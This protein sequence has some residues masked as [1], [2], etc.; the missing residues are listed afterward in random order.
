MRFLKRIRFTQISFIL[1]MVCVFAPCLMG[2][3]ITTALEGYWTFDD[4]DGI[5]TSDLSGNSRDA[6][7]HDGQPIPAAGKLGNAVYFDGTSDFTVPYKGVMGNTSR[8]ISVW[9][10]TG[11][12]DGG[13]ITS[14]GPNNTGEKWHFRP[15]HSSGN[16]VIGAI[17]T[18][19][20]GSQTVATT[21]IDDNQWHHVV[22]VFEGDFP[23]NVVHYVD[24][25]L[26]PQSWVGATDVQI[27]TTE[28]EDVTIG[29]R[30]QGT[31]YNH[32]TGT[33]DEMRI[34]SR[35]LSAE[36]V[37]ALYDEANVSQKVAIRSIGGS[38][39]APGIPIDVTLDIQIP[40]EG[41]LTEIIPIGW[42]ASSVSDGGTVSGMTITWNLTTAIS[43]VSYTAE[44][45]GDTPGNVFQGRLDNLYTGGDM[46][47]TT[48]ADGVGDF[49]FHSDIGGVQAKG[50]AEY[51]GTE[52]VIRGSGVD[53]WGTAD[54]F[55]YAFSEIEGPFIIRG[56]AFIDPGESS[57]AWVKGGLMI[58][59]N[60]S[61]ASSYGYLLVRTDYQMA[62]QS[63]P[64]QGVSA[65]TINDLFPDQWGDME[66]ERRGKELLFFYVDDS[67]NRQPFGTTI[68]EDLEDPVYYGLAVTSHEN[69]SL[70]DL[71][72]TN[73]EIETIDLTAT[74]VL[75]YY[76]DDKPTFGST[77]NVSV[78]AFKRN[79]DS[80]TLTETPPAGWVVSNIQASAGT[81]ELNA[82]GDIIL[83][84]TE[85]GT[86]K[87]TYDVTAPTDSVES[88]ITGQFTGKLGSL[89][90]GGDLEFQV[91]G[92]LPDDVLSQQDITTGL[93]GHWKF[94]EGSGET[95]ADSSGQ[96]RTAEI[97]VGD[98]QW[99]EGI[100][101]SALEF[102]GDD[103]LFVPDWYGI[104]G[105]APRALTCWIKSTATNTHGILSWG[106]SSGDGQKYHVRINDNSGNGTVGAIRS[107]IQGTFHIATTIIND[108]EWHFVASVFPEDGQFVIDINHYIDGLLEGMSGTNSSGSTLLLDTAA[109][110]D[111]SDQE[112]RIGMSVQGGSDRYFPGII[113]EVR[114][115]ERGLTNAEIQAIFVAEGGT[116]SV[117][118][119]MLY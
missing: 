33:L 90:V 52:Y 43:T 53:V 27:N 109:S 91:A 72:F 74:R 2:Q 41:V 95:M 57:N 100:S 24:G 97:I 47:I 34:Y 116:T 61:A 68:V 42:T 36:D 63:R 13:G 28:G 16:G 40:T 80:M 112:F 19:Y 29:S 49:T 65:V 94:D 113:D 114:V 30:L 55:H 64:S 79:V 81:A 69:G 17:R 3:D 88:V 31:N 35:A 119:Y 6:V 86:V 44:P 78:N 71:F 104:E 23:T 8:S 83:P 38:F 51:D 117:E 56:G 75:G 11:P 110:P 50:S 76:G 101:G 89:D 39:A 106:L 26:D 22:C 92:L 10:K 70:S 108:G 45:A 103:G 48:L 14:W 32:I 105:S 25:A 58:R 12:A 93:V 1:M 4:Y 5:T 54:S 99:I 7:I 46:S 37:K 82:N 107:E 59:N 111:V 67:G 20:A 77:I 102:D 98:P 18:E 66:I 115:Y 84:I 9:I 96:N 87:L 15:N 85:T 21:L 73:F 60:L 118:H 62:S